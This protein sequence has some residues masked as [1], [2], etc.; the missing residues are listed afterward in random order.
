[1]ENELDI[2]T[3]AK[4]REA[5]KSFSTKDREK[6]FAAMIALSQRKFDTIYVKHLAGEIK[7]LKVRRYRLL[8]FIHQNKVHFVRIFIKKTNKTPKRDLELA[9]Q[10]Y[11]LFV[12]PN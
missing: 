7:E 2:I 11:K 6:I 12:N 5:I 3:I 4:V 10:Y 8:F 1:M 9:F